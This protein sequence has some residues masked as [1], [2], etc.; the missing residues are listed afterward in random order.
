MPTRIIVDGY[1]LML[2]GQGLKPTRV[3][4][5][6]R[7]RKRLLL[8]LGRYRRNSGHRITVAF[9]G[10]HEG[11]IYPERTEIAGIEV[12]FSRAPH[13]ADDVIKETVRSS[14]GGLI[15][16]TSDL[17]LAAMAEKGGCTT[18]SSLQFMS[19]IE[20]AAPADLKGGHQGEDYPQR[21]SG[22]KKRG[23]PRRLSK[24]ERRRRARLRKL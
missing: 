14:G 2:A 24:K 17:E 5:L 15:V 18:I 12:V 8:K 9:D 6:E 19:R 20:N 3:P 7:A 21:P 23:N 22:T 4:D 16:V 1:N 13:K 10:S 11:E